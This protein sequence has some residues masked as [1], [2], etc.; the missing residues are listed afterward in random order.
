MNGISGTVVFMYDISG[1]ND[2]FYTLFIISNGTKLIEALMSLNG[3]VRIKMYEKYCPI[4]APFLKCT[5][6]F[7]LH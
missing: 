6:C 2:I 4:Q 5:M 1:S 7:L 3:I